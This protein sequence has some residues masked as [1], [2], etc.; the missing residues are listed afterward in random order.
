MNGS[1]HQNIGSQIVEP[2][3]PGY[4]THTLTN[5]PS[6]YSHPMAGGPSDAEDGDEEDIQFESSSQT[7]KNLQNQ[8]RSEPQPVDRETFGH[9]S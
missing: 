5:M 4:E 9:P 3:N 7:H 2:V 8:Y 1:G 6:K